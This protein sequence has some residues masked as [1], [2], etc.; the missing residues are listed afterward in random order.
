MNGLNYKWSRDRWTLL[1]TLNMKYHV[2]KYLFLFVNISPIY[3]QNKCDSFI[4]NGFINA[5]TGK[6]K[7]LAINGFEYYPPTIMCTEIQ[8]KSGHFMLKNISK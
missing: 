6:I 7:L 1:Q 2:I 4:L 3:S 5:D 8:I